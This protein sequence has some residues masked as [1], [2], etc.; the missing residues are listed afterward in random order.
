MRG[1]QRRSGPGFRKRVLETELG[2]RVLEPAQ[3]NAFRL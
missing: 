2:Q 3:P 1:R